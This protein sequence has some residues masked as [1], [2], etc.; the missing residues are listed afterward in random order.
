M[1]AQ[2]RAVTHARGTLA[3]E[4]PLATSLGLGVAV[5]LVSEAFL[6]AS[7]F[8]IYYYLRGNAHLHGGVLAHWPPEGVEVHLATAAVNTAILLT[9]SLT[10]YLAVLAIRQGNAAG[11]VTWLG[12]TMILGTGFLAIK[13]VEW[14]TNTFRPWD[15]AYGSIYYTLTGLHALHVL[16]GLLILGALLIRSL[17][18]RFSAK[19][20]LAV[21]LGAL[22]WHFVDV[23]WI[24]VF[25]TIYLVR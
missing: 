18:G 17:G 12:G 15:H 14:A 11:L 21:E 13:A 7:L 5:F 23:V 22:Y 9:S 4:K 20:H 16:I 19:R 3:A 6:F 1:L 25:T 24:A 8:I 10:S 2:P